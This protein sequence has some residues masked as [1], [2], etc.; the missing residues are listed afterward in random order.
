[1]AVI[2]QLSQA[3]KPKP[4]PY[5]FKCKCGNKQKALFDKEHETVYL[6]C[7]HCHTSEKITK[8]EYEARLN[9]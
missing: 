8:A 7:T 5:P 3:E 2:R 1:M 6:R 9:A 4:K